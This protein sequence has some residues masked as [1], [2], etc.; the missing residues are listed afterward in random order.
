MKKVLLFLFPLFCLALLQPA[1]AANLEEIQARGVIKIGV[2]HDNEPFEF[3]DENKKLNGFDIDIMNKIA[4]TW[5]VKVEFVLKRWE[6][7]I[8][9]LMNNEY[10]MI[11]GPITITK[12]R[13]KKVAFTIP[14]FNA[15]QV[16]LVK[17]SEKKIKSHLDLR[18][19][20]IT[21]QPETTGEIAAKNIKGAVIIPNSTTSEGALMVLKGKVAAQIIDRPLALSI[22]SKNK[23][24]LKIAGK[25]LTSEYYGYAVN[26]ADYEL[27]TDLNHILTILKEDAFYHET[28]KKWF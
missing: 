21:A 1:S 27:L 6:E 15:G 19:R 5:G 11:I 7:L 12:E 13:A 2:D 8:P 18:G 14:H 16:M 20:K 24:K 17:S 4:E 10:D 9:S 23:G 25:S 22:I 3:F 28:F 26:K